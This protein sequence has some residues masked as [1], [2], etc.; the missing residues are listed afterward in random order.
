MMRKKLTRLHHAAL[1]LL[2]AGLL[3][4]AV[5]LKA[6]ASP[7]FAYSEERWAQLRDDRLE[8]EEIADLVHEYNNTVIQNRIAYQD[9]KDK[10][11]DDIAQEYYDRANEIYSN[12]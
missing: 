5:P 7:D 4:T 1:C 3:T 6:L 12:I 10:S 11:S 2:T 8:F 9:E